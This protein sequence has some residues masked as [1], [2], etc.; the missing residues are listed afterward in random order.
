MASVTTEELD[1]RVEGRTV[2]SMFLDRVAASP[3]QVA[4]RW[5]DGEFWGELSWREWADGSA[6]VATALQSMGIGPGD[7]V[8]LMMRNRPEFH[9]A[10]VGA[11]LVGATPISVYNSSSPE[12]VAYLCGHSHAKVAIVEDTGYLSRFTEVRGE[13]P[14]LEHLVL[15][16]GEVGGDVRSWESLL[17][18]EPAELDTAAK[19]CTPGDLATVIYTSGT[20]GPPKGVQITHRNVVFTVESYRALLG[21]I[22]NLRIVSYLPMAHVAERLHGHWLAMASGFEVTTCPDAGMIG[23]YTAAV[24]PESMFGVPRVW[25][26]MHAAAEGMLAKNEEVA[27]GFAEARRVA[28]PLQLARRFRDLTDVEQKTLD[29]LDRT[30]LAPA[31]RLLGLDAARFAVTGAAPIP[32]E[33]FEWFVAIGVAFSEIYGMS[34]NTGPLT[35]EPWRIKPG[36]VGKALPGIEIRLADDGEILARGGNIF[37]GYLDDPEKT[38]E[39]LDTE[40]WLHTGDIGVLDEE[41]YLRIVD[42]KK[43]LI[44]TAGGKNIS[45][46]NLESAMRAI[47]LV[48]QACAIG[49]GRKFVSA[50]ITLDPD[51]ARAWADTHGRPDATFAE[52]A[53]DPEVVAD[54]NAAVERAMEN[55]NHAEAVKKFTILPEEWVPDS[56][57]LTPTAKLKRR[58]I[59]A[60]FAAEI[61]AMYR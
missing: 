47:P 2:T 29:D 51:G 45:P 23:S 19:L 46:A 59:H 34:E 56:D 28:L 24:R 43:E 1:E 37:P 41:G 21:E 40:G 54:L 5:K 49:D 3:H 61:E 31:R 8:L 32:V 15:V 16:D 22:E 10:D 53:T 27:A 60:K 20:T 42:R 4:L 50:L 12:Q 6:R 58:N 18:H 36:T 57:E 55:F 25:E 30:L 9:I 48:G 14:D 39:A 44:I 11:L 17:A 7:R 33:V 52:L 26:K 38:A 35:W 13:L